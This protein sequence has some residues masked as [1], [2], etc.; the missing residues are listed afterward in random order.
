M[1]AMRSGRAPMLAVLNLVSQRALTT[2]R[3]SGDRQY[4]RAINSSYRVQYH[5]NIV[6]TASMLCDQLRSQRKLNNE[7]NVG[8]GS[9]YHLSIVLSI[10]SN[11]NKGW[12]A[13]LGCATG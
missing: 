7:K 8:G 2:K 6:E 4:V 3:G 11:L 1:E 13:A 10:N 12:A 5:S 9:P